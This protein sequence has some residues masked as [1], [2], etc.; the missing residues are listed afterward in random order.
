MFEFTDE[1]AICEGDLI[2]VYGQSPSNELVTHWVCH[3]NP[4]CYSL[5]PA[6]GLH[7]ILAL[8]V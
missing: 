4:K 3:S 2:Q 7:G 5:L 1:S 6:I 8:M